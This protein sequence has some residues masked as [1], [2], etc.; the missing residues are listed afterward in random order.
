[1]NFQALS[2]TWLK[3]PARGFEVI[4]LVRSVSLTQEV[5]CRNRLEYL[6]VEV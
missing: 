1:M 6:C 2:P 5:V 4:S 3:L